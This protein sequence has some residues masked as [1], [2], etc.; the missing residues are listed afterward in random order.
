M[1]MAGTTDRN[2]TPSVVYTPIIQIISQDEG[3]DRQLQRAARDERHARRE[4]APPA[5]TA[6]RKRKADDDQEREENIVGT[7]SKRQMREKPQGGRLPLA[8]S[9]KAAADALSA[10][11]LTLS[12]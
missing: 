9:D 8:I 2:T 5:A 1:D 12:V 6:D 3:A 11:M 4:L 10:E 7:G